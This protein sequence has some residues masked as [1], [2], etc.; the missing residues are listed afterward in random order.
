MNNENEPKLTWREVF[1]TYQAPVNCID[2]VLR[3]LKKTGYK[4]YNW[5]GKIYNVTDDYEDWTDTG[6]TVDDLRT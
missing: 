4:Y 3:L 2:S 1:D 6:L 5:N